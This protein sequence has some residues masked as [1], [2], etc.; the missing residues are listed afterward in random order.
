M[1]S[2]LAAVGEAMN[3]NREGGRDTTLARSLADAY[4]SA[5]PEEFADLEAKT[6]KECV[7][8]VDVFRNTGWDEARARTELW[9][10]HKFEFQT[11]GGEAQAQVRI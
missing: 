10:L 8:A 11:I 6:L 9:I 2:E 5:H 7:E 3:P 4:V 1:N